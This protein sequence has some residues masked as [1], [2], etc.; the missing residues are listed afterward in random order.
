M[1]PPAC[2]SAEMRSAKASTRHPMRVA[3][4]LSVRLAHLG[5]NKQ[6]VKNRGS[7]Y[8]VDGSTFPSYFHLPALSRTQERVGALDLV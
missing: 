1:V 3:T 2:G 5:A 7:I 4:V 6:P 8:P